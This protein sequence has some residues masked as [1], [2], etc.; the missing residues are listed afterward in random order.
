[1]VRGVHEIIFNMTSEQ[2]RC[3]VLWI[4]DK[5]QSFFYF[6]TNKHENIS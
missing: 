6:T 2:Q 3:S 1:M 5:F 4:G